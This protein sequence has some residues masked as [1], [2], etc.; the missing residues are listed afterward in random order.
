MMT[1]PP[2][3]APAHPSP[4][5]TLGHL[6]AGGVNIRASAEFSNMFP[7]PPSHEHPMQSP[8]CQMEGSVEMGGDV[9]SVSHNGIKSEPGL[10]GCSPTYQTE[11]A[12]KVRTIRLLYI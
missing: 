2:R 12:N 10:N 8:C 11:D 5:T 4:G 1:K 9:N 3:I 7:T 6:T